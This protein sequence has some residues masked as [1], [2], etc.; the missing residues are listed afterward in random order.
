MAVSFPNAGVAEPATA[1]P[2]MQYP[3]DVT[4]RCTTTYRN[5][6][7]HHIMQYNDVPYHDVPQRTI[8]GELKPTITSYHV[9]Y[10]D[11][12]YHDVPYHDVPK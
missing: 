5:L 10:H 2:V 12:P 11:V 7:L 1:Y 8:T 6:P 4:C 3:D 9:P